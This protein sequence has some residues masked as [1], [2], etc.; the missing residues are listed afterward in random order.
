M[1]LI[2][3]LRKGDDFFVDD[4]R[5]IVTDVKGPNDF[6]L[7]DEEN[8]EEFHITDL[9]SKEVR[10]HVYVSAGDYLSSGQVRLVIEAPRSIRILRGDKYRESV[11]S[12]LEG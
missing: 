4:A 8:Q 5:V 7:C 6:T 12:Y 10:E 9:E 3:S 2:L 1:A 11:S